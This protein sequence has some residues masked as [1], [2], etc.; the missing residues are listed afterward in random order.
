MHGRYKHT[1]TRSRD[2]QFPVSR[3][4]AMCAISC[5]TPPLERM[6]HCCLEI[7]LKILKWNTEIYTCKRNENQ[8]IYYD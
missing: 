3:P 6:S 5:T 8:Y 1:F 7:Q 4:F 2:T